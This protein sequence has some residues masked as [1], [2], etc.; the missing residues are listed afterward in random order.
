LDTSLAAQANGGGVY[1]R[2]R[3]KSLVSAVVKPSFRS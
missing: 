1:R 3:S 2:R